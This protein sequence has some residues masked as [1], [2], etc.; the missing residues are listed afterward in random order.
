MITENA[1]RRA[2]EDDFYKF[3]PS[4]WLPFRNGADTLLVALQEFRGEGGGPFVSATMLAYLRH[5]PRLAARRP[6]LKSL[7]RIEE[8][9]SRYAL[10]GG[11]SMPCPA[12]RGARLEGLEAADD[13]GAVGLHGAVEDAIAGDGLVGPHDLLKLLDHLQGSV[14]RGPLG[15]STRFRSATFA[16]PR[17]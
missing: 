7:P 1:E 2:E 4:V 9:L 11:V 14:H 8:S 12:R 5:D 13:E 16:G 6:P 15:A 3:K 17:D 10:A